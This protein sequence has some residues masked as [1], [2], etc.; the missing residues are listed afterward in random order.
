MAFMPPP[1][2]KV[3]EY[4]Q[5]DNKV[6]QVLE[7]FPLSRTCLA[8]TRVVWCKPGSK[9]RRTCYLST[10]FGWASRAVKVNKAA[11]LAVMKAKTKE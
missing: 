7:L 8:V 3:G 11:A 4:W 5:R 1:T 10:W 6:R 9:T 2:P